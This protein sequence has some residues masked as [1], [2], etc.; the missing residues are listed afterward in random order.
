MDIPDYLQH[1]N[2]G[3]YDGDIAIYI[4]RI[5]DLKVD[6]GKIKSKVIRQLSVFPKYRVRKD[7]SVKDLKIF[8]SKDKFDAETSLTF[9]VKDGDIKIIGS[10][11]DSFTDL[12]T[13]RRF[14]DGINDKTRPASAK[15]IRNHKVENGRVRISPENYVNSS[16]F[17]KERESGDTY[18][19]HTVSDN[20]HD[21]KTTNMLM[22]GKLIKVDWDFSV[23]NIL[24]PGMTVTIFVEAEN[25]VE[26][27]SGV[28]QATFTTINVLKKHS[29]SLLYIFVLPSDY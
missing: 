11:L 12:K 15:F 22:N 3:V 1:S 25:K 6:G 2:L 7:D 27:H 8:L 14:A 29:R 10:S 24:Y 26:R 19:P 28:L 20:K 4:Q 17:S 23:P 16:K 21:F 18:I 9:S 5:L 13:P